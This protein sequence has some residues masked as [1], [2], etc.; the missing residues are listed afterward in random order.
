MCPTPSPSNWADMYHDIRHFVQALHSGSQAPLSHF[1]FCDRHDSDPSCHNVAVDVTCPIAIPHT[2]TRHYHQAPW[3][4]ALHQELPSGGDEAFHL[5][6][7]AELALRTSGP[8]TACPTAYCV[9][10]D[11]T[12]R[13]GAQRSAWAL[14]VLADSG[15]PT[16][17]V[18]FMGW[19]GAPTAMSLAQLMT[20]TPHEDAGP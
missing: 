3:T 19:L 14:G 6:P 20:T 11:A 13:C 2:A 7:S 5:H 18:H 10:A 12:A 1:W 17:P 8:W 16:D 9:C 15:D 4:I